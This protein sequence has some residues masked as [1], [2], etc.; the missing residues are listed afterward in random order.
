ME[1]FM[2][3]LT[4]SCLLLS[5]LALPLYSGDINQIQDVDNEN[6]VW[7]KNRSNEKYHRNLDDPIIHFNKHPKTDSK[8][9][10]LSCAQEARECANANLEVADD[11]LRKLGEV[12]SWRIKERLQLLVQSTIGTVFVSDPKSK[13]LFVALSLLSDLIVNEGFEKVEICYEL[14]KTLS[15]AASF[16]E[17]FKY[18]SQLALDAKPDYANFPNHKG[19]LHA[20]FTIDHLIIA[21][22]LTIS[23][24][25]KIYGTILSNH[26]TE[27]RSIMVNDMVDN[28]QLTRSYQSKIKCLLENY[29][30]IVADCSKRDRR[31]LLER[32]REELE[33][34]LEDIKSAEIEYGIKR[35]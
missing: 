25:Y 10:I 9:V 13:F 5:A 34:A 24:Q 14:Y 8:S 30:E 16:L 32:I 15:C 35:K 28:R 7:F 4:S 33:G 6:N 27:I 26:I 21:D 11:Y 22:M 2:K 17:E 29:D 31:Y 23:L 20:N 1:L 12:K 18:Y 3:I 19:F